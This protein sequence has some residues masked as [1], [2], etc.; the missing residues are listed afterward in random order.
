MLSSRDIK[1]VLQIWDRVLGFVAKN[2]PDKEAAECP[3]ILYDKTFLCDFLA[4]LE[5]RQKQSS[6]HQ[7]FHKC[8]ADDDTEKT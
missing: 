8:A 7:Y 5:K 6:F 1:D 3:A 4:V 2:Y